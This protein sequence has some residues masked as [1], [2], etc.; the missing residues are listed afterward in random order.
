MFAGM[1]LKWIYGFL[2]PLLFFNYIY[3]VGWSWFRKITGK[4]FIWKDRKV[5]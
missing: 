2:W 5:D 1:R 4:G 3:M